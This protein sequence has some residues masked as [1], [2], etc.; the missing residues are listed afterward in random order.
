MT[1]KAYAWLAGLLIVTA[2]LIGIGWALYERGYDAAVKDAA[3][4]ATKQIEEARAKT[5]LMQG[6]RDVAVTEQAKTQ[7]ALA[8][9]S[10]DLADTKYRLRLAQPK[11]GAAAAVPSNTREALG[12]AY[13]GAESD[14]DRCA[15]AVVGFSQEAA[16][17]STSARTLDRAYPRAAARTLRESARK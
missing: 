17:A 5:Q 16:T 2:G 3:V 14:I 10:R 1:P 15:D 9:A 12:G 4:E 11:P 13:E 7:A 6:E 8:V